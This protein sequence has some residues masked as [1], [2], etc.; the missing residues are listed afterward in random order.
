MIINVIIKMIIKVIIKI[1]NVIIKMIINV[2]IKMIINVLIKM[3]AMPCTVMATAEVAHMWCKVMYHSNADDCIKRALSV[4]QGQAVAE[5]RL[6][7]PF[8]ANLQEIQTGI[9]PDL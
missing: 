5:D 4:G 8:S 7:R 1:I 9:A 2:I 3:V 6:V